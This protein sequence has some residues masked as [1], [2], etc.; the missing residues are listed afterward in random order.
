MAQYAKF[1]KDIAVNK[2]KVLEDEKWLEEKLKDVKNMINESEVSIY[3]KGLVNVEDSIVHAFLYAN[4]AEK[5]DKHDFQ[6][7]KNT[8]TVV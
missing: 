8:Q 7:L 5:V 1:Y 4:L 3:G 6:H 2:D